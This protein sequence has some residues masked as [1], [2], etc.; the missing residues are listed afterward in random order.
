MIRGT[1]AQFKYKLPHKFQDIHY[2]EVVFGQDGNNDNGLPIKLIYDKQYITVDALPTVDKASKT[3]I[4]C[5]NNM[6]YKTNDNAN[7]QEATNPEDLARNDGIA[8]E[9]NDTTSYVVVASLEPGQSK[10]FSDKRKGWTQ[11][12]AYCTADNRLMAS[13]KELFMVYPMYCTTPPPVIQPVIPEEKVYVHLDA[14][15]IK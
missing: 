12:E 4:Y 11:A 15:E 7:W 13:H 1:T 2:I 10:L 6:F 14:G 5:Y 9:N 3:Q 8:P